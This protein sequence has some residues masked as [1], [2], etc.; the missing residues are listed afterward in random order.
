ML[1]YCPRLIKCNN[2]CKFIF[3]GVR[4]ETAS[5]ES[6][7]GT[8]NYHKPATDIESNRVRPKSEHKPGSADATTDNDKPTDA[9][10]AS[11]HHDTATN[12]DTDAANSARLGWAA[13]A[14]TENWTGHFTAQYSGQDPARSSNFGYRTDGFAAATAGPPAVWSTRETSVSR[15]N[16]AV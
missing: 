1:L 11:R 2:N 16:G 14:A 4:N 5:T 12:I 3:T 6:S 10:R 9:N 15:G 8:T 13:A 7:V